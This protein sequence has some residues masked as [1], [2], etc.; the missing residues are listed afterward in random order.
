MKTVGTTLVS[1]VGG[2]SGPLYGTAFLRASAVATNKQ[3]LSS[4]DV[5]AL[6]E[7]FLNGIV[8]RGKAH[9][10]E[11]TMID[12]LEPA[13]KRRNR[14]SIKVFRWQKL[15]LMPVLPLKKG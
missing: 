3:E 4:A 15:L 9:A 13:L 2:A 5:V 7:A 10:G 8:T 14:R 11:K 12:A 6:L 1:T